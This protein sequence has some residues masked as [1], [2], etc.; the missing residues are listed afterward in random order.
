MSLRDRLRRLEGDMPDGCAHCVG[1]GPRVLYVNDP[2]AAESEPTSV[3][4]HCTRCGR[5]PLTI[6]VI[7]ESWPSNASAWGRLRP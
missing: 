6:E 2:E 4:D 7:Y 3:P 1:W 5:V